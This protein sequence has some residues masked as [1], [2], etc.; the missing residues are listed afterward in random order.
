MLRLRRCEIAPYLM[1]G[2]MLIMWAVLSQIIGKSFLGPTGYNTYTLQALAW[3]N[4]QTMLPH[5]YPVL[6]LAVYQGNYYVSFPPLPSVILLPLTFLFGE[7]TP[8]HA[9]VKLYALIACLPLYFALRRRGYS[10]LS[11]ALTAFLGCFGSSLLPLTLDGAVWYHA[12]MLAFTLTVLA[13]CCLTLD[14]MTAAL[15]FYALSVACRPFHALY[16]VP[17]FYVY[18]SIHQRQGI[19]L[20]DAI[21]GLLPGVALGLVVA[22]A[23]GLY[24]YVRFGDFFEFG[25]NHLPEFSFQGGIQFSLS[26]IPRNARTFLLGLPF[27]VVNGAPEW[28]VFGY[29]IFLAC[30][31]LLL[32]AIWFVTDLVK[33]RV[34]REHAVVFACA[35]VHLFSLLTHR[36]FGGFQL[37]AR[38]AVDVMP[39]AF[40][41]LLLKK[42]KTRLCVW[43]GVLLGIVFILTM[44]GAVS[45]HV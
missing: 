38:Y 3:R 7:S 9:L 32:Q 45:V 36:T 23:L 27:T 19:R 40:F 42:E 8:D 1:V 12:Q 10:Q 22:A 39:Y 5:D 24:N 17:L 2:A 18:L 33:R 11:A 34:T 13:I 44:C 31:M 15:L 28:N 35:V 4:G 16:A 14:R 29:S 30:P 25:H 43:E 20:L 6:E 21:E 41:Y 37:G 26:H